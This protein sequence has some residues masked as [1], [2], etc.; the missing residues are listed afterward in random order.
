LVLL[1]KTITF[2]LEYLKKMLAERRPK[3]KRQKQT[4]KYTLEDKTRNV[5]I[6]KQTLKRKNRSLQHNKRPN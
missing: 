3:K 4:S 6:K 2:D 1:K 5:T